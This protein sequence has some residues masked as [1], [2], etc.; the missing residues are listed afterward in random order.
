[1]MKGFDVVMNAFEEACAWI[2]MQNEELAFK[3]EIISNLYEQIALL[4]DE[5]MELNEFI[6][7]MQDKIS[8]LSSREE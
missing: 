4:E 5:V 7:G 3:E 6:D 8:S 2:D 1:M